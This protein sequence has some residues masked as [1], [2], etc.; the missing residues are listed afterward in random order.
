MPLPKNFVKSITYDNGSENAYHFNINNLLGTKSFF[1]Q[2]Y[3]AWQKGAVE[4]TNGLIRRFLPKS[5]NFDT[6]SNEQISDIETW[7]NNRPRKCLNFATP[8][9]LF[10]SS[11]AL[12]P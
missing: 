4:N 5:S 11:V 10:N 1:C 6:I 12:A 7:L 3:Q 2:P 8:Q 9:E